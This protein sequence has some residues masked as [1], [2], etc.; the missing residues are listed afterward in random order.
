MA[1]LW[2]E[3]FNDAG[4]NNESDGE[5][6]ISPSFDKGSKQ[7]TAANRDRWEKRTVD[8]LNH[9]KALTQHAMKSVLD[10]TTVHGHTQRQLHANTNTV[11][12]T[13]RK[14][15]GN[16]QDMVKALE[17]RI[18]SVEDTI[19]QVGECLF[20]LQ[21]AFRSKWSTLNVCERRLQL[22]D[23]RPQQ[24]LIR[25]ACQDALEHERQT[26]VESRQEIADHVDSLKEMLIS[27]E[28]VKGEL[29]DDMQHKRHALR[30]D[31]SCLDTRTPASARQIRDRFVLPVLQEVVHYGGPP[32]PKEAEFGS[33]HQQEEAR[34]VTAKELIG[35]AV[36]R[37]EDAMRLCNESDAVMIHTKRECTR[38]CNQAQAE[39]TR[40]VDETQHL[41]RQLEAQIHETDEAIAQM[42]MSLVGTKKKMESHE[43]PLRALDKQFAMRSGRT[44]REGIRDPVHDELEG[45]L[46]TVKKNVKTLTDKW[47]ATKDML[48][49]LR[50]TKQRLQEDFR[51]KCVAAKIDDACIKVTAKKAIE[52]DRKDPRG[53]RC[54]EPSSARRRNLHQ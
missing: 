20:Q 19:R 26:L 48:D 15:I 18:E 14:K 42:E 45:H 4:S 11:S 9:A 43:Q 35:K 8:S 6:L 27:L 24:E 13:I 25:D 50:A 21:R 23:G 47:Q 49:Q 7:H 52:L 28:K 16:T 38:A 41:R 39:L 34:Q 31:R 36:Q 30:I 44:E 32:S 10:N 37:E 33:G 46:D 51:C 17:D 54:R 1:A 12:H 2:A 29:I 40:R 3:G 22:R 5:E 53:G